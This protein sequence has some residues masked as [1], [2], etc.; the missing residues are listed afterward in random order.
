MY[1][2]I[3][4]KLTTEISHISLTL[5]FSCIHHSNFKFPKDVRRPQDSTE[6][7]AYVPRLPSEIVENKMR[8]EVMI[9][10]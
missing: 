5:I 8:K 2:Y 6:L 3:S 7:S 1:L 4:L 9:S 10:V